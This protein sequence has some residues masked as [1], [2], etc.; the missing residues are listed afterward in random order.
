MW[1]S[2]VLGDF[3]DVDDFSLVPLSWFEQAVRRWHDLNE[4]GAWETDISIGA[5]IARLGN[6]KTI[7]AI[8]HENLGVRELERKPKADTM[9]T[10]GAIVRAM[11]DY[12]ARDVRV[13]ADGIGAGVYDRLCEM[14]GH[15]AADYVI[16][17][18]GGMRSEEDPARYRNRRAE[19]YWSLRERLDP[20]SDTPLALPPDDK[21]RGQLTSIRWKLDSQGRIAIES[22]DDMA[23]R[24]MK[25]PDEADACAYACAPMQQSSFVFV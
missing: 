12:A 3:P 8:A 23:K 10:T 17:M 1:S 9:E 11:T 24:G 19:W 25:S 14:Y 20:K 22:K 6:D 16:E 5:D 4:K 2:R 21:L 15:H 13:D 18:R 7:F